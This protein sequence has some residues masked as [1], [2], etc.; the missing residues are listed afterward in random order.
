[1]ISFLIRPLA[2]TF[3]PCASAQ[4][5]IWAM[6]DRPLPPLPRRPSPLPRR[7]GSG[8]FSTCRLFDTKGS[9]AAWNRW[10]FSSERSISYF[11]V[12]SYKGTKSAI[13]KIQLAHALNLIACL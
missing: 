8:R 1:M 10:A 5:R 6:S 7:V 2:L 9:S 13:D 4:A 12:K 11:W 3:M